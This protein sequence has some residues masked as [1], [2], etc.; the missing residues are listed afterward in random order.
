MILFDF[1][2]FVSV[3]TFSAFKPK[4]LLNFKQFENRFKSKAIMTNNIFPKN[5]MD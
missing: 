1:I 2:S 5:L 3:I 4:E